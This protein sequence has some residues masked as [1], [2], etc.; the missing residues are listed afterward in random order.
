MEPKLLHKLIIVV[1]FICQYVRFPKNKPINDTITKRYGDQ[2]LRMFRTLERTS[3]RV[4]KAKCHLQ[5]LNT[6]KLYN[7]TP[8]FLRFK[9]YDKR[10]Y[11]SDHYK[12][13]Q[14]RL[15]DETIKCQ[16]HKT[17]KLERL[18][19]EARSS[20]KSNLDWID[21]HI[22][23]HKIRT[24]CRITENNCKETHARKLKQ[25]GLDDNHKL[26]PNKVV[27]NLSNITL[28]KEQ[29]ETLA[30]GLDYALPPSRIH[31]E[32]HLLSFEK[33]AQMLKSQSL[34][35]GDKSFQDV[36]KSIAYLANETYYDFKN[37]K[38]LIPDKKTRSILKDL[39]NNPDIV[40]TKPDKGRAVVILNKT[41]YI[42]KTME[43]INDETKF[44]KVNDDPFKLM[45]SLQTK[46][47]NYLKG[48]YESS[49]IS[50]DVYTSLR[51][52]SAKPGILYG[53][54]KIHK[55]TV[56]IRPIMSAI[57]TFNYKLSKFI[58]P[59]ISPIAENE[60]T[61]RSTQEFAKEIREKSFDGNI[62]MTSF[63]ISSL[64]TNVPTK[65]TVNIILDSLCDTDE[66]FGNLTR[67]EFRKMLELT[68][69]Q[70]VFYFNNQL[71]EQKY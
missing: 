51:I 11:R 50:L 36:C 38:H 2:V 12:T 61:I 40:I 66:M 46:L 35:R 23:N 20:L 45:L 71:Y 42:D 8:K 18:N 65:E 31:R 22:L 58:G 48:L 1:A 10:L 21:F 57:D 59:L 16:N 69:Q 39:I 28:T 63:D 64:Y 54:P 60:H 7:L 68:T 6:C 34:R 52:S 62:Y 70:N 14:R 37:W 24:R 32:K 3:I 33:L 47:N 9:L 13:Y 25:I 44:R 56:P 55:S 53:L 17:R 43:I 67:E 49:K 41:D 27:I 30:L 5:F 29:I 19:I 15:L 26:D 4:T